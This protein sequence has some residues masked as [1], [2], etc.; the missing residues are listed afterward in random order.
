MM[1]PAVIEKLVWAVTLLMFYGQGRMTAV[2]MAAGNIPH[3]LLGVL[4]VA[5]FAMTRGK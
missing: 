2:E 5:A 4:F 1:V 3:G